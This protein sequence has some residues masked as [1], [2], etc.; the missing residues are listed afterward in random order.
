MAS[1]HGDLQCSRPLSARRSNEMADATCGGDI[2]NIA[3]ADTRPG[4]IRAQLGAHKPARTQVLTGYGCFEE[5]LCK[6]GR[7]AT[8]V[9]HHC[10]AD[11]DTAQH[12]LEACPAWTAERQVFVLEIE[13]NFSLRAV[14]S[15]MLRRE[16]A[17]EAVVSF[18]E[19]FMVQK[20]IAER[21]WERADPARRRRPTGRP[22]GQAPLPGAE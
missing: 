21:A 8:A 12:T 11:Q 2:Y 10:G 14:V 5:Y 15:A 20:E 6:I 19:T 13:R 7:E 17:W 22:P 9:C 1:R 4:I 18:C 16:S 3:A